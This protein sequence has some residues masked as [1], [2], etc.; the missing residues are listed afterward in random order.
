MSI[1][2][3]S[4]LVWLGGLTWSFQNY[5]SSSSSPLVPATVPALVETTPDPVGA[6]DHFHLLALGDSL[7]KGTGDPSGKGYVGYLLEDLQGKL[8]QEVV[9]SNYGVNGQTT[10]QLADELNQSKLQS[11]I[12]TADVIVISIGANDL[13]QSGETLGNLDST[14]IQPIEDKYTQQ[15]DAILKQLRGENA[16]A[17]IY[18]IGLYNPFSALENAERTNEIIRDWNYKMADTAAS[19]PLTVLVPTADIF[20]LKVQDYLA[21]DL[22]HPNA[23]GYLLMGD[24]VASLIDEQGVT[25]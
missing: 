3:I 14:Y 16:K 11:E 5:F 19:F 20:Q 15:L 25:E 13:F 18:L 12:K 6:D 23:A 22:F 21:R 9:V 4:C 10:S 8:K 2:A 7:T 17:N 24:R 1:S